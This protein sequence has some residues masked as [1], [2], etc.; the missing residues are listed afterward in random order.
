M[1]MLELLTKEVLQMMLVQPKTWV[2][3]MTLVLHY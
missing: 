3:Q 1:M 2:Q